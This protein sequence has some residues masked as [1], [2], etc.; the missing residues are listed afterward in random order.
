VHHLK[1]RGLTGYA[2]LVAALLSP[3]APLAPLVPIPRALT[4]RVRYGIDP[5]RALAQRLSRITGAPVASL[6][7]VPLHT[8]RRAGG[9]HRRPVLPFRIRGPLPPGLVLVDDVVTTG[10][11]LESAIRS[12]GPERVLLAIAANAVAGVV[13]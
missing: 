2:D 13:R 4:R 11:T 1:Y 5:G 12:L 7:G 10:A 3:R 9:D 8:T 6:L